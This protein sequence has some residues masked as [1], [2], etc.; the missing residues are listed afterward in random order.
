M[1]R[2]S[3]ATSEWDSVTP[4]QTI[5]MRLEIDKRF[6]R[7]VAYEDRR[8]RSKLGLGLTANKIGENQCG[9]SEMGQYPRQTQQAK[10]NGLYGARCSDLQAKRTC[11]GLNVSPTRSRP[12]AATAAMISSAIPSISGAISCSKSGDP[13]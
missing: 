7:T 4:A 11:C 13:T 12:P 8:T 9:L 1:N 10:R 6:K 3:A 5:I 2:E